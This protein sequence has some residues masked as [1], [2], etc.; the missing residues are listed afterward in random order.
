MGAALRR[1]AS[2]TAAVIGL[3]LLLLV[4]A[5]AASAGWLFPDDP[6]SLAGA[7]LTP[8]FTEEG[9]LLGTDSVGR[10]IAAQIFHGARVSLLVG[11]V[12]TGIAIGIGILVGAVSG[13]FGGATDSALMRLTEAFQTVPSFILLLMLVV[14]FGSEVTTLALVIGAVSWTAPARLTRA[15][16]L[17]LRSRDFVLSCR[18]LGMPHARI[19]FLEILPSALPPVIVY[20][21]VVMAL[22]ILQESALAFLGLSD[23]NI[24]S[25]GNLIGDGRRVLRSAW[26]VAALP[27]L[28]IIVTVL[29]ISLVGQGV[30]DL[31]NPRLGRR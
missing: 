31:L 19:I 5:M 16:F 14:I 11:V 27:G 25:W 24:A 26:Y 9:L 3:L 21:S 2:S 28:A 6:L 15:E 7:P 10:D 13:Y 30:N 18:T 1:Y 4:I 12:A 17:T 29:A 23:P 8:P 20:V 22:A